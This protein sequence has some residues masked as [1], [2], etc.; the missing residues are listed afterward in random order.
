MSVVRRQ[1]SC[2]SWQRKEPS[3]C[4]LFHV[5]AVVS[6]DSDA[7]LALGTSAACVIGDSNT[8]V[9]KAIADLNVALEPGGCPWTIWPIV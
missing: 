6:N 7:A 2:N 3:D 9:E 1:P 5:S 4:T 8:R